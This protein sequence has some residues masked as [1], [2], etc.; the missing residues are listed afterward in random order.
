MGHSFASPDICVSV[1]QAPC[2]E[3][4]SKSILM[5]GREAIMPVELQVGSGPP[6]PGAEC[7]CDY[8]RKV[9]EKSS[10]LHAMARKHLKTATEHQQRDYD[11]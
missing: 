10:S 4:V 7:Y 3:D 6:G 2:H 5:T 9:W 11:A 8:V 1:L